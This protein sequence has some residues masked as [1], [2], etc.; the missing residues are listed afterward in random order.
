MLNK[1]SIPQIVALSF[2]AFMLTACGGSGEVND[3][4]LSS[5]IGVVTE[6]TDT[7]IA[8]LKFMREEEKLA[9]DVYLTLFD[10][11]GN[12]IFNNIASS[13]Q[14]HTDAVLDLLDTFGVD[15]PAVTGIGVFTNQELQDL[16]DEL[17]TRGKG[18]AR[19]AL[20]VGAFIEEAD[21]QDIVHAMETINN[22]R[23]LEVYGNLLC[24]SRN[25]L[26]AFVKNIENQGEAYSTQI[27]AL[28]AE[29]AAI[30][31]SP[32]EQCGGH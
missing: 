6:V 3:P 28:E 1:Y 2:M 25:H 13:E 14:E 31:S 21:I 17:I 32:T 4:N 27:Q 11:W 26:R 30:L 22:T 7:E 10:E 8:S 23:M 29:V 20:W 24:G 15:D 16:S 9:R 19:S 12:S 5:N 18:S